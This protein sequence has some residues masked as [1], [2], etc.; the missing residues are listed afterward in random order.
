[1]IL[2][3]ADE[4]HAGIAELLRLGV[5][6]PLG[7]VVLWSLLARLRRDARAAGIALCV[8]F[9]GVLHLALTPDHLDESR[10]AGVSFGVA[11]VAEVA[12]GIQLL[13]A[14][15][16]RWLQV[17]AIVI[18]SA[19]IVAY[20]WSR[21]AAAPRIGDQ[22]AWDGL[23][24]ITKIVEIVALLLLVLPV[25]WRLLP[26]FES[27]LVLAAV[28][29]AVALLAQP[30]FGFGP[31]V[32]LVTATIGGAG[33]V[34]LFTRAGLSSLP[35]AVIDGCVVV[36]ALRGGGLAVMT[37]AGIIVGVLMQ[38]TKTPVGALLAPAALTSLVLLAVDDLGLRYEI[39]HAGHADD[40]LGAAGVFVA[41]GLL[42]LV[43][44][45]G[46]WLGALAVFYAVV[47]AGQGLR[48]LTG[49]TSLE[50]VEVPVTS[51]GLLVLTAGTLGTWLEHREIRWAWLA[52]AAMGAADVIFRAW[53]LTYPALSAA[54][55]G[56]ALAGMCAVVIGATP[57]RLPRP[58]RTARASRVRPVGR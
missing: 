17:V 37:A 20:V 19:A 51:V 8:L 30:V 22:E 46:R 4:L 10:T 6:L 45:R 44:H 42:A 36:L 33:V 32:A 9:A 2:A 52:A 28:M 25:R 43:A 18:V 34:A 58:D 57:R 27:P 35:I 24:L 48:V 23:G 12:I 54:A 29:A 31:G 41:G 16:R 39:L 50:A 11:G 15:L 26:R 3:H 7:L 38:A 13:L 1:M 49:D 21:V 40:A 55:F 5:L 56:I 47:L 53:S 14:P